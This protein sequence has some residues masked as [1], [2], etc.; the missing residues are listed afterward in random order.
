MGEILYAG[1]CIA[2]RIAI[3]LTTDG[4]KM[5]GEAV[6]GAFGCDV[7]YAMLI[8]LYGNDSFDTKYSPGECIG[9]KRLFSWETPIQNTSA[10][11][12]WSGRILPCGCRCGDSPG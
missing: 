7:D 11:R 8:K 5:Y 10:L 4:L 1:C 6:E 2:S 3:Q 9:T 12:L